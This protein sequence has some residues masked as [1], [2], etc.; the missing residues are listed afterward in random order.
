LLAGDVVFAEREGLDRHFMLGFISLP[1]L[2]AWAAHDKFIGRNSTI[3]G[4]S[5][6]S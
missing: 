6:H 5:G 4:H 3:T 2:A 1:M